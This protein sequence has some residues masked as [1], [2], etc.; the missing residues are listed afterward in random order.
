[1]R[2]N[3]YDYNNDVFDNMGRPNYDT[4]GS[5]EDIEL[6]NMSD[7]EKRIYLERRGNVSVTSGKNFRPE[8]TYTKQ[9]PVTLG[10]ISEPQPIGAT[11]W[12]PK[13]IEEDYLSENK[14]EVLEKDA[15]N[16]WKQFYAP[17]KF[18]TVKEKQATMQANLKQ[19]DDIIEQIT[20]IRNSSLAED[21]KEKMEEAV[22]KKIPTT[23]EG[24]IIN[25]RMIKFD[26]DYRDIEDKPYESYSVKKAKQKAAEDI[27][28]SYF[29]LNKD[30]L[31]AKNKLLDI[32]TKI[33]E[34]KNISL[35]IK[36]AKKAEITRRIIELESIYKPK[37]ESIKKPMP[38]EFVNP[39]YIKALSWIKQS[40]AAGKDKES[41]RTNLINSKWPEN[42]VDIMLMEM[43]ID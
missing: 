35:E 16:I 32:K 1:M 28:K 13:G 5:L 14:T 21:Q 19:V 31:S 34:N 10:G 40:K 24:D 18:T 36:K 4:Y 7:F 8:V 33:D 6:A 39:N 27:D 15:S 30:Y 37:F 3:L 12:Q 43:K 22:R 17:G 42:I 2:P 29:E 38:G 41:I 20:N 9:G 23:S 26:L 25:K 11:L